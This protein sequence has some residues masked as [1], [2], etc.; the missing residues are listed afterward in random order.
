MNGPRSASSSG[1]SPLMTSFP[2]MSQRVRRKYSCRGYDMK[3][4]E[5]VTMPMNR[6]SRPVFERASSC[7]VIPCLWSRNHHA[8]PYCS[9]PDLSPSWK[10][11][12]RVANWKC[13]PRVH[14]IQDHLRQSVLLRE[15]VE[16]CA[17]MG[18]L[19]EITNGI[20]PTSAPSLCRAAVFTLR[21]AP[22]CNCLVHRFSASSRPKKA[23]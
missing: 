9:F 5:S 18:A 22:R 15:H 4:R 7:A 8:L 10:Q 16:V 17:E 20:E 14:V 21:C 19:R 2:M 23:S 1:N 12:I 11:P 6:D 3:D 13:V